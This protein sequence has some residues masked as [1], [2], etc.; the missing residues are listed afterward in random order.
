MTDV[1]DRSDDRRRAAH[2]ATGKR[3]SPLGWLPWAA[4][5][6]LGLLGATAFLIARNVGD[7]GDDPG[8]DVVDDPA[9][10]GQD[11][12]GLDANRDDGADA[13]GAPDA[14]A[15][16]T[17]PAVTAAP[18]ASTGSSPSTVTASSAAAVTAAASPTAASSAAAPTAGA[19]PLSAGNQAILPVPAAGLAALSGQAVTGTSVP[20][21]SVVADEGFW[22]GSSATER[23]FVFLTPEAR[24]S[25]GESPFQVEAGQRITLEGTL[26]PL[27]GDPASL[28]VDATEG[29]DQL[30]QQGQLVQAARVS[31]S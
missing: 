29:A 30:A 18:A 1:R 8:V 6:L 12:P 17:A 15:A 16:S 21:E 7:A 27:P 2:S 19:S 10:A 24:S 28:G 5:A 22:V 11:P 31:L 4:L 20:V 26:I 25:Q 9:A 23:V 14:S 3:R 13:G